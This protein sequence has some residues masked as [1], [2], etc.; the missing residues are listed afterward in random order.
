MAEMNQAGKDLSFSFQNRWHETDDARRQ[1][2]MGFSE[3]YKRA[4]DEGKT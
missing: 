3:K 4:L 1:E 2:I